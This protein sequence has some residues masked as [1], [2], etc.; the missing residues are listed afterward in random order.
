MH[1]AHLFTVSS[2]HVKAQTLRPI[3]S[4]SFFFFLKKKKS[5]TILWFWKP[6]ENLYDGVDHKQDNRW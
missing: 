2:S 5:L 6:N 4:S 1:M 3:G